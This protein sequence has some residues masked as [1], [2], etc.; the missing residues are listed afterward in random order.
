MAPSHET[1][2]PDSVKPYSPV[3]EIPK[4]GAN[5]PPTNAAP[6]TPTPKSSRERLSTSLR[7]IRVANQPTSTA[8]IDSVTMFIRGSSRT[9]R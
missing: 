6:V 2:V 1:N 3:V 9:H 8:T 7:R 4:K 5:S